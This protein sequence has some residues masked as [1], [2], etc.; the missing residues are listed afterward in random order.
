MEG[1][2]PAAGLTDRLLCCCDLDLDPMT[3]VCELDMRLKLVARA[4]LVDL[5]AMTL[6]EARVFSVLGRPPMSSKTAASVDAMT[7][8]SISSAAAAACASSSSSSHT[9]AHAHVY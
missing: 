9:R 4:L 3:L 7:A 8:G 6:D 1:R 5:H 2:R